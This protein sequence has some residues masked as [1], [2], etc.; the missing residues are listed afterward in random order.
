[1]FAPTLAV[2]T[3]GLSLGLQEGDMPLHVLLEVWRL[4]TL[5]RLGEEYNDPVDMSFRSWTQRRLIHCDLVEDDNP[6]PDGDPFPWFGPLHAAVGFMLDN[7]PAITK[8]RNRV[9]VLDIVRCW[10]LLAGF[11]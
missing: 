7:N 8:H 11:Q 4:L 2:F 5:K 9:R 3:C 10:S 6:F 1:M